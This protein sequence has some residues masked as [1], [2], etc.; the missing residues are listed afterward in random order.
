MISDGVREGGGWGLR[1]AGMF[2]EASA[3]K[4]SVVYNHSA[5]PEWV[6]LI[7][8]RCLNVLRWGSCLHD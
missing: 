1:E 7:V 5:H 3:T 8:V 4:G 6:V 2:V